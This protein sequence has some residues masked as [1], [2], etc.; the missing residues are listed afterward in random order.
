MLSRVASEGP[1]RPPL[2][3]TLTSETISIIPRAILV[4][5]PRAW[6]NEVLPGSIP[7][8]PA[9]MNTSAGARAPALAGA[10]TLLA[11]MRS[12]TSL[13]SPS[14]KTKPTLPRT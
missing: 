8:G 10:A 1:T 4:G 3:V 9:G 11:V 7:V 14:V 13:R 2:S 12:R 6:K 5:I